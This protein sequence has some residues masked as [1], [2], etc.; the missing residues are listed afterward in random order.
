M[1]ISQ[2][3]RAQTDATS[4]Q[5]K[6]HTGAKETFDRMIASETQKGKQQGLEQ[7]MDSIARQGD[8][9]ARFRSFRDFVKFK[10][11]IKGF[12]HEAVRSS[13][14]L[15]RDRHFSLDGQSKQLSLVEAIDEKLLQLADELMSQ[16]KK[17]VDL[18][19]LI[20]EIK[21]LLMNVYQ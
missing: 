14:S 12:L 15:K 11:M 6:S 9:L 4:Q 7:L 20:G 8:K 5:Q 19:G 16:E 17:N 13:F 2:E 3:I 18:L 1:K 21:G 10:R